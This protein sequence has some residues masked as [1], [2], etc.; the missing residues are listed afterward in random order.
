MRIYLDRFEEEARI[1]DYDLD[2][3]EMEAFYVDEIEMNGKT[4]CGYGYSNYQSAGV[5]RI[6]MST[7]SL[8]DWGSLNDYVRE[9]FFFMK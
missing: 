2:L 1:R 3:S 6:E 9:G 8:C 5:R 7:E 4:F